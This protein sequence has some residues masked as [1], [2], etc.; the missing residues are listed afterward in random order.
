MNVP[1]CYGEYG[2]TLHF[3]VKY[4][5]MSEEITWK[6]AILITLAFLAS[7]LW[8]ITYFSSEHSSFPIVSL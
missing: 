3:L 7:Y 8:R 1:V 4:F 5:I 2:K 6:A